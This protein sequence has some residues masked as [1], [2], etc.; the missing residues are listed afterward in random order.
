MPDIESALEDPSAVFLDLRSPFS[1]TGGDGNGLITP[2]LS[3]A[4]SNQEPV[5]SG[6]STPLV[7]SG[8]TAHLPLSPSNSLSTKPT[9]SPQSFSP[10]HI[11]SGTSA[12]EYELDPINMLDSISGLDP[13]DD[14]LFQSLSGFDILSGVGVALPGPASLQP[15]GDKLLDALSLGPTFD[16]ATADSGSA[17]TPIL[18][19][20][21]SMPEPSRFLVEL[22]QSQTAASCQ[23]L[24]TEPVK[25]KPG[26]KKKD[27]Q[28]N[29]SEDD[30]ISPSAAAAATAM[31]AAAVAS[32]SIVKVEFGANNFAAPIRMALLAPSSSGIPTFA[33]HFKPQG[34]DPPGHPPVTAT[35]LLDQAEAKKQE[36]MVKNREAAD[37]SRKRKK[38]HL[39]SLE[40]HAQAL[41]QENG[42][43]KTR[44]AELETWG[45]R[46]REQNVQLRRS[47]EEALSRRPPTPAAPILMDEALFDFDGAALMT[48]AD[49]PMGLGKRSHHHAFGNEEN[50]AAHAKRL[51]AVFAVASLPDLYHHNPLADALAIS[52]TCA[53]PTSPFLSLAE[54]SA[55]SVGSYVHWGLPSS[56]S[57]FGSTCAVRGLVESSLAV[58][59]SRLPNILLTLST[60]GE[61]TTDSRV[62]AAWLGALLDGASSSTVV[63][64]DDGVEDF[65]ETRMGL[66]QR[67]PVHSVYGGGDRLAGLIDPRADTSD[68]PATELLPA[69]FPDVP[70]MAAAGSSPVSR[71]VRG[72]RAAPDVPPQ[73]QPGSRRRLSLLANLDSDAARRNGNARVVL[74]PDAAAAA[75]GDGDGDGMCES[76]AAAGFLVQLDVE[77]VGA[78]L[79]RSRRR[80]TAQA[81]RRHP[82]DVAYAARSAPRLPSSQSSL[83]VAVDSRPPRFSAIVRPH[84]AVPPVPARRLAPVPFSD[85]RDEPVT[86][87]LYGPVPEE[88]AGR[89]AAS[90]PEDR[91]GSPRPLISPPSPL[92]HLAHLSTWAQ[93]TTAIVVA[94][95]PAER[96]APSRNPTMPGTTFSK[97]IAVDSSIFDDADEVDDIVAGDEDDDIA[98]G[99]VQGTVIDI[100]ATLESLK[101]MQVTQSRFD[102]DDEGAATA[103]EEPELSPV[104]SA[105]MEDADEDDDQ[106]HI[107][108][109]TPSAVKES[110][111][112][113]VVDVAPSPTQISPGRAS[114][115]E[116]FAE[117]DEVAPEE[118]A[119]VENDLVLS[120]IS[121][122]RQ[123]VLEPLS[124]AQVPTKANLNPISK[125]KPEV[126]AKSPRPY[127]MPITP[128]TSNESKTL[129]QLVVGQAA[130]A[131]WPDDLPRDANEEEASDD[132]SSFVSSRKS[133]ELPTQSRTQPAP[134]APAA[135][136]STAPPGKLTVET[137]VKTA[138]PAPAPSSVPRTPQPR[139]G[140]ILSSIYNAFQSFVDPE[141]TEEE[142][143]GPKPEYSAPAKAVIYSP[144]QDFFEGRR[145]FEQRQWQKAVRY[146]ETAAL[147]CDHVEAMKYLADI[148]QPSRLANA[149]KAAEW[150]KRRM[151]VLATP[152]G[153]LSHGLFVLRDVNTRSIQDK[154]V[155]QKK[156][157]EAIVLIRNAADSGYAPAMHEF[158]VYLRS[159]D[160]GNEAMAW[161][162]KAVEHGHVDSEEY[163][164]RGY[165]S[166]IGIPIDPVAGAHWRSRVNARKKVQEEIERKDKERLGEKSKQ[167]QAENES[168]AKEKFRAEGDLRRREDNLKARRALDP[169]LN[170]A[171]RSIEWGFYKSGIEALHKLAVVHGNADAQDFLNPDVSPISLRLAAAMF[172]MGQ[173]H[174]S[175][176]DFVSAVKWHRRAAEG[177]CHEAQVTLAAYLIVGKGVDTAD[178]GQAMVWLMKAWESG[179]NKEAAL[180]LGEAYTK[181]IGV[182]PDPSKAVKWYTRAW[183]AGEY[184]EAAFAVGLA[185]AT[186]YTPG[187]VDPSQWSAAG[188]S[189]AR[190][191]VSNLARRAEDGDNNTKDTT[192][193]SSSSASSSRPATPTLSRSTTPIPA[194]PDT[195]PSPVYT[196]RA[197]SASRSGSPAP[198]D[199]PLPPPSSS[200]RASPSPSIGSVSGLSMAAAATATTAGPAPPRP[201]VL[202][203]MLAVRQDLGQAVAWYR[204]AANL[205]HVRACNNLGELYMTGRGLIRNDL[206]GFSLFRRSAL[207]GL[208]EAEYNVGRCY[209]EGRG[210][211]GNEEEA[212][213]W[214]RKAE[215]HGIA[216]GTKAIALIV[217]KSKST[218][219]TS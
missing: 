198:P 101:E 137:A 203:G 86:G 160:K 74:P 208:P 200:G 118:S 84:F 40:A 207:A 183:E 79:V 178:P 193:S 95:F 197:Y 129:A 8:T 98:A 29:S 12:N 85:D 47:L 181:G 132:A 56:G 158:A 142:L 130:P 114:P 107:T 100:H 112:S 60:D 127:S 171:L 44:V 38:E 153:M 53:L 67:R 105:M 205:G 133:D 135:P 20:E 13:S 3:E 33:P 185:Y 24:L 169:A 64:G 174:A 70:G 51:G 115:V 116:T 36:R 106:A 154:A 199:V 165:E 172:H 166:G 99:A 216:E 215:A 87:I 125:G 210:C 80:D 189:A 131:G 120:P 28:P 18:P 61:L 187:A 147:Q 83:P 57:P 58:P 213:K 161:F 196:L 173:H 55:L 63:G 182:M 149:S 27:A 1:L 49:S 136:A 4:L 206:V 123:S 151:A 35:A 192:S 92:G 110:W 75:N 23:Q 124:M 211:E 121:P 170:S 186:G 111:T 113:P 73:P 214:L 201:R 10:A 139:S 138:T 146:F 93:G 117:V 62:H 157:A 194:A 16:A 212:L 42:A 54:T 88:R 77:V 119:I 69:P 126:L 167:M 14:A 94:S 109:G 50:T 180:A 52:T 66:L 11:S 155:V 162:H 15:S 152:T 150:T 148:Y 68:A 102:D 46:M 32:T 37:Q 82:L 143:L 96:T 176:A 6:L 122:E 22:L 177:G 2:G 59:V 218:T 7:L 89:P 108:V 5:G 140:G 163:L 78:R 195:V 34:Q 26:R 30:R 39:S 19:P 219:G 17:G 179:R 156:V 48:S 134:V 164:A 21:V 202:K 31:G 145:L 103:D 76:P 91:S 45:A 188:P 72:G 25:R 184:P 144:E 159:K 43:L 168:R 204:K 65:G 9:P 190:T 217:G 104:R 209:K 141:L 191:G 175:H 71:R 128:T 90:T 97:P 41:I 81:P